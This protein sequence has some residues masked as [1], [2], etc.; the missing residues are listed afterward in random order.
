VIV[1]VLVGG[2]AAAVAPLQSWYQ[3]RGRPKYVTVTVSR[4]RVE[5]VVNS[6]GTIK[7]VRSVSVGAFTS[8]PI[9]EVNV[10]FNDKVVGQRSYYPATDLGCIDPLLSIGASSTDC[11]WSIG[12]VLAR[13]DPLLSKAAVDRDR[14]ALE[15]LIAERDRLAALLEQAEKNEERA[16]ALTKINED[17]LSKIDYDQYHYTVVTTKAQLKLANA[18]ITQAKA[19]LKNSLTNL[20]YTK[21]YSPEDGIV[22]ERKVDKGQTVAASFQT[23][24]LFIVAPEMEKHM[25]VFAS[26]DEADIGLIRTAKE[27]GRVVKFTIDAYPGELFEGKIFQIRKNS[28]TTQNV[29]TYP[30]VIDAPNPDMKLMPGMTANLSFQIEIRENTLRVPASVLRYVP[31]T[32]LVRLDDRH[33]VETQSAATP[34]V[35]KKRSASEKA[36]QARGRQH[37]VV[38]VEDG[39][40]LKAVPV[41]LG[42]IE[43]QYVEI[44]EGDLKEGDK[45]VTGIDSGFTPR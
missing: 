13:I 42:L 8:G 43:N 40:L 5:T 31:P 29:V 45:V 25:H 44:L 17:Y 6:T 27:H 37:R 28:S 32:A 23:P 35:A 33:H 39:A 1:G 11:H 2:I 14:A 38:W 36:E 15:S 10:D 26:V 24:E 41:T 22:I 30:V 19:T 9:S 7:P 20:E 16:I 4:G 21:I 12:T 3:Q 34:E 18:N